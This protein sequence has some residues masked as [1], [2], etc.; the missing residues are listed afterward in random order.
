MA[1]FIASPAQI[2]FSADERRE[3]VGRLE[4]HEGEWAQGRFAL[5]PRPPAPVGIGSVET[6]TP[7][8]TRPSF[9][10]MPSN[11]NVDLG[12]LGNW[13]LIRFLQG[14]TFQGASSLPAHWRCI[15]ASAKS[16]WLRLVP[17]RSQTWSR[18]P[19]TSCRPISAS[20][21]RRLVK[22]GK[23]IRKRTQTTRAYG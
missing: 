18:K 15:S 9:F 21:E 4:E 5:L 13:N 10:V 8:L 19:M 20:T 14:L 23:D 16:H 22:L 2:V 7:R 1:E 12:V 6:E 3:L 17:P 11:G